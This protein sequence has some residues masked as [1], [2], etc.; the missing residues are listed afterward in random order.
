M[1]R[2][3][4]LDAPAVAEF[5]CLPLALVNV[6]IVCLVMFILVNLL[7]LMVLSR[8]YTTTWCSSSTANSFFTRFFLELCLLE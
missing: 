4:A 7:L 5:C 8:F 2:V 3:V 1:S 6:L